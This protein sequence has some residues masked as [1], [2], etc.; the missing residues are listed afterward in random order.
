M[1][2]QLI[3]ETESGAEIYTS[4]PLARIGPN[5]FA[6]NYLE[7]KERKG[8]ARSPCSKSRLYG[9]T[10]ISHRIDHVLS[11]TDERCHTECRA[12]R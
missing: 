1:T 2:F 9:A 11:E 5:G 12:K 6:T 4:G 3:S 7:M 8:P 10:A